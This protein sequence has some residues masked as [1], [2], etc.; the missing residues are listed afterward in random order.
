MQIAGEFIQNLLVNMVFGKEKLHM[1]ELIAIRSLASTLFHEQQLL[2]VR[3]YLRA[4]ECLYT[5]LS[6]ISMRL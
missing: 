5:Y 2:Y 1:E 6:H 4:T 3:F